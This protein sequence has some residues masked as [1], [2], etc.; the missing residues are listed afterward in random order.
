[1]TDRP[2]EIEKQLSDLFDGAFEA[3]SDI[4]LERQFENEAGAYLRY[5]ARA[6]S[7]PLQFISQQV[8]EAWGLTELD[9]DR[10]SL[11]SPKQQKILISY[12]TS[13]LEALKSDGEAK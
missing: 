1:M 5:R 8:E 9:K 4:V 13:C 7:A 2:S 11:L 3:G 10:Y 6:I 12:H